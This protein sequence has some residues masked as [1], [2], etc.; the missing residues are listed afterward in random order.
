M[1]ENLPANAGDEGSIPVRGQIPHAR[2]L[3]QEKPACSTVSKMAI[4]LILKDW[5]FGYD[6]SLTVETAFMVVT[7]L[8]LAT[9]K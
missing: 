9:K 2:M 4:F 3:Q 8:S 7:N 5:F 1:V 6:W